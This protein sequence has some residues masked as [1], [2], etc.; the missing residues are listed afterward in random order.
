MS[1]SSM[2]RWTGAALAALL[3]VAAAGKDLPNLPGDLKLG[4]SEDSPGQVT[5]RHSSHVD[6]DRPACL[7]CHPRRFGILGRSG[8]AARPPVTH[9]AM[10][11]GEACGACHGKEAFNFEDCSNCHQ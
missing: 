4:K 11:K 2:A 9:A 10:E 6:S 8:A 7:S 5:F 1:A 3:A